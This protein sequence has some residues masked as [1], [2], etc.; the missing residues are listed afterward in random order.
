LADSAASLEQLAS[1]YRTAFSG[2]RILVLVDDALDARDVEPFIPSTPSSA[3]VVTSPSPLPLPNSQLLSLS[4]L[5]QDEVGGRLKQ[6]LEARGVDLSDE[7]LAQV[8]AVTAGNPLAVSL[9]EAILREAPPRRVMLSLEA[10]QRVIEEAS[11]LVVG[12]VP[13]EM[14]ERYHM[15]D[16]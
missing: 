9:T 7:L 12:D 14:L 4:P 8:M 6:V 15:L 13:E 2:R 16:P 10:E 1:R 3:L 11:S 5:K